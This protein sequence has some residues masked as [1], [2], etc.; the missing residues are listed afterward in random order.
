MQ[1]RWRL[2]Q[3]YFWPNPSANA[4]ELLRVLKPGGKLLIGYRGK[5]CM[6]QLELAKY[7]FEKYK[8]ED[9]ENLINSAGFNKVVSEIIDEPEL[10]FGGEVRQMKGIYTTG[11]K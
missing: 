7:N 4:K 2:A 3:I 8:I 1:K 6:D 9:V 10:K 5:D 11:E